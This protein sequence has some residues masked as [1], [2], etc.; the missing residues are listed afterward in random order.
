MAYLWFEYLPRSLKV[1]A[2]LLQRVIFEFVKKTVTCHHRA[3]TFRFGLDEFFTL[4]PSESPMPDLSYTLPTQASDQQL[5]PRSQGQVLGQ[6]SLE[7]LS[8][9]IGPIRGILMDFTQ[10]ILRII[11]FT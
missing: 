5:L 8:I 9:N 11:G 7:L 4:T 6:C 2:K 3:R 1:V 10:Y